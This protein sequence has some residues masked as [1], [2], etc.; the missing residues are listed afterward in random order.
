MDDPNE[1]AEKSPLAPGI[2]ITLVI[3]GVTIPLLFLKPR[4]IALMSSLSGKISCPKRTRKQNNG[5]QNQKR[6]SKVSK[7]VRDIQRS[8]RFQSVRSVFSTDKEDVSQYTGTQS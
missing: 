7:F 3:I 5:G 1:K 8:E 6:P 4:I 2:V